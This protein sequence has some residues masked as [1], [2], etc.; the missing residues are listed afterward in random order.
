MHKACCLVLLAGFYGI[1]ARPLLT[2]SN[3]CLMITYNILTCC[4]LANGLPTT[5]LRPT[6]GS[7]SRP[8]D[9]IMIQSPSRSLSSFT[10][11]F[12]GALHHVRS[13]WPRSYI[14]VGCTQAW[15]QQRLFCRI[16]R[17]AVYAGVPDRILYMYLGTGESD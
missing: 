2:L 14:L 6:I 11:P 3:P 9:L 17:I 16:L 15:E 1:G 7:T 10:F 4:L 8:K 13:R 12:L 5:H